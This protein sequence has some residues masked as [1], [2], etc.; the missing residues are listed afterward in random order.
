MGNDFLKM[1]ERK[2]LEH[3]IRF[4]SNRT[5]DI[6]IIHNTRYNN[7]IC[8][9]S[10]T[11]RNCMESHLIWLP[12]RWYICKDPDPTLPILWKLI[13]QS[14]RS[15]SSQSASGKKHCARGIWIRSGLFSHP[16]KRWWSNGCSP[17]QWPKRPEQTP[18]YNSSG[19][20]NIEI[21]EGFFWVVSFF[22]ICQTGQS[23]YSPDFLEVSWSHH[24]L[25]RNFIPQK[26]GEALQI[27]AL[28]NPSSSGSYSSVISTWQNTGWTYSENT[29]KDMP[30]WWCQSIWHIQS[31]V[32]AFLVGTQLEQLFNE[33]VLYIWSYSYTNA[34]RCCFHTHPSPLASKRFLRIRMSFQI[35]I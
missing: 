1:P 24:W 29:G 20:S 13:C 14:F 5:L 10:N 4:S 6:I 31:L 26:D 25:C 17:Y 7:N 15:E 16:K 18:I 27:S 30:S 11:L 34:K 12:C 8:L 28:S 23:M 3:L 35:S 33:H 19:S 32:G 21:G 9:S 2:Y 22:V